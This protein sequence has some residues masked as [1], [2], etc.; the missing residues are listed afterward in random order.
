MTCKWRY[1]ILA[2]YDY[3]D[4]RVC[5]KL[6]RKSWQQDAPSLPCSTEI[7]FWYF[8]KKFCLTEIFRH[9]NDFSQCM[10]NFRRCKIKRNN[11]VINFGK[12]KD[13]KEREIMLRFSP[14]SPLQLYRKR[15]QAKMSQILNK[16]KVSL[17]H[18]DWTLMLG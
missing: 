10:N 13:A 1:P 5:R 2:K 11:D 9:L 4:Y 6:V 12:N 16:E 14:S 18:E 17:W 15:K 3:T 7:I 8:I